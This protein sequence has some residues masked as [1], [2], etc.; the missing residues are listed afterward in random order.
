M[1]EQERA[2]RAAERRAKRKRQ[3]LI[4]RIVLVALVL[5]VAVLLFLVIWGN[6][7]KT[8]KPQNKV[9]KGTEAMTENQS[10][11][12]AGEPAVKETEAQTEPKTDTMAEAERLAA[13]YDYDAAIELLKSDSAFSGN[14][15]MAAKVAEWEGEKETLVEFPL[16][17]VT[18][19]FYH[20]LIKDTSLAFD[21]DSKE[22][23]YNQVM[24]TIDE[25]NKITQSM[26]EKGYVMVS[27]HDMCTVKEGAEHE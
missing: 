15:E 2:K 19:V 1:E 13:M 4:C 25:F 17:E 8:K 22:G 27:L 6:T 21:G 14:Q 9:Q 11:E 5:L 18:H 10:G 7:G 24:T 20:T 26:Y 12:T 3:V 23:G 16:E